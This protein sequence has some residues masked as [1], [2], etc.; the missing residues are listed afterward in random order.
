ML[1]GHKDW[2]PKKT[3]IILLDECKEFEPKSWFRVIDIKDQEVSV[4]NQVEIPNCQ[5]MGI[6]VSPSRLIDLGEA[7]TG[8]ESGHVTVPLLC[9]IE[10]YYR[11]GIFKG[12][13]ANIQDMRDVARIHKL[14]ESAEK[15]ARD[16]AIQEMVSKCGQILELHH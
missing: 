7:R 8:I 15:L 12:V 4:D 11:L 6:C 2:T 13:F 3:V 1:G 9:F 10:D 16:L 14:D 5:L